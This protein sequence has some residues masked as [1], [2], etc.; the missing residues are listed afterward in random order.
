RRNLRPSRG[1]SRMS[2]RHSPRLLILAAV[3]CAL[4]TCPASIR[5]Q[6]VKGKIKAVDIP[7]RKVVLNVG[8]HK[9]ITVRLIE[10]ASIDAEGKNVKIAELKNDDV[11]TVTNA[12]IAQ[13]IHIEPTAPHRGILAEFWHN[14]THNLFKPLLLF[15]YMGFLV[16]ILRVK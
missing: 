15:F 14:F 3:V 13:K 6:E 7:G 1:A 16:P 2:V 10:D 12:V 5:A 11:V 8:A 9:H 4:A